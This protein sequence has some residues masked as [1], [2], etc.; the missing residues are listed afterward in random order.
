MPHY[1]TVG[2][3][4]Q[5]PTCMAHLFLQVWM[6]W[7]E[8]RLNCLW[9]A[10]H[11]AYLQGVVPLTE[12]TWNDDYSNSCSLSWTSLQ[13]FRLVASVLYFRF[14]FLKA[15]L[16]NYSGTSLLYIKFSKE[17]PHWEA[18]AEV[19]GAPKLP[20]IKGVGHSST[21]IS[22]VENPSEAE[23]QKVFWDSWFKFLPMGL[24]NL[25]EN[26]KSRHTSATY[27]YTKLCFLWG[28]SPG[29]GVSREPA[30]LH[31]QCL[32][33]NVSYLVPQP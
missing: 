3:I 23:E 19:V 14:S 9:L 17:Y 4:G 2:G 5:S 29:L 33:W 7:R 18:K 32:S 28:C 10:N 6:T 11:Y 16:V 13:L 27:S 31:F 22:K 15:I 25:M 8:E 21:V 30:T 12:S 24:H 1:I 26:K 20:Y